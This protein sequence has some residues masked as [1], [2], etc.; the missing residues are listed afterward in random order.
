[1]VAKL[2]KIF[3]MA[4][5]VWM[6]FS[7]KSPRQ[8]DWSCRGDGRDC[9]LVEAEAGDVRF[10]L[11]KRQTVDFDEAGIVTLGLVECEGEVLDAVFGAEL[12]EEVGELSKL[13]GEPFY[14]VC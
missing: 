11:R 14:I 9:F 3:H 12:H 10:L 7:I 13:G 8:E 2:V 4:I 6:F 1:M 5:N